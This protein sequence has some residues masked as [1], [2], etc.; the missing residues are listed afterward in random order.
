MSLALAPLAKRR[1]RSKPLV[2]DD[3]EA[4]EAV[5]HETVTQITRS[6]AA[7][8]KTILVP[9]VP[10]IELEEHE[11]SSPL[12]PGDRTA[13]GGMCH[14]ANADADADTHWLPLKTSKVDII[15]DI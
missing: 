9:L 14:N 4:A 12:H 5:T 11:A 3:I 10:L 7:K 2:E 15:V 13:F 8:K 1:K 6:C